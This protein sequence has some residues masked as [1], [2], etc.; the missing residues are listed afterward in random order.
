VLQVFDGD[1]HQNYEID[2]EQLTSG[3]VLC[4][5]HRRKT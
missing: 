5:R 2:R 3:L 1:N 4:I